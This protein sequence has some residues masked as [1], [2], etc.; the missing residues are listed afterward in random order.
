MIKY[1]SAMP[2]DT[3]AKILDAA[4][5]LLASSDSRGPS[6]RA[7][8]REA[9][10]NSALIHYHFGSRERLFE[11]AVLLALGPIQERRHALIQALQAEGHPPSAGQLA[12]LFVEPLLPRPTDDPEFH[13]VQLKLL[14]RA[15]AEQRGLVQDL[16]L[17]HFGDLMH[18]LG[19]LTGEALPTLSTATKQR[20]MRFCVQA[21][22][23]TLSGP[24][25]DALRND[26]APEVDNE[27]GRNA[28]LGDLIDFLAGGLDAPCRSAASD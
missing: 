27:G 24:E 7:I 12:R 25:T 17:K 19:D 28:L 4:T 1:I 18:A 14:A 5:R 26:P 21:A 23:E 2:T 22:L 10:V 13:A 6:L 11:A 15:F 8:A 9:K 20:R 16:T 3:R